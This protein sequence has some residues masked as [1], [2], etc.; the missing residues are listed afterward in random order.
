MVQFKLLFI[1]KTCNTCCIILFDFILFYWYIIITNHELFSLDF[2]VV[3]WFI[4]YLTIR[5]NIRHYLL[6]KSIIKWRNLLLFFI[7]SFFSF[8]FLWIKFHCWKRFLFKSL[9]LEWSFFI[10]I[11]FPNIRLMGLVLCNFWECKF[12]KLRNCCSALYRSSKWGMLNCY[13]GV[14]R[15]INS[16]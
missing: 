3:T 10:N 13:L 4:D 5:F 16:F 11:Y 8:F 7:I 6:F 14:W 15:P 9:W 1:K 2:F 12:W